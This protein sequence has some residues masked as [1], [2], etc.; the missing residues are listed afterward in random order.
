MRGARLVARPAKRYRTQ[1]SPKRRPVPPET[2]LCLFRPSPR[3]DHSIPP[4]PD[5]SVTDPPSSSS[6][7]P[8]RLPPHLRLIPAVLDHT[9]EPKVRACGQ[10][11][12]APA[13]A[14]QEVWGQAA[15]S[16]RWSAKRSVE[17]ANGC[18][19]QRDRRAV[20]VA[21]MIDGGGRAARGPRA[22]IT[23]RSGR[24]SPG[25]APRA[26]R[27]CA[28]RSRTPPRR[29]RGPRARRQP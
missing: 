14:G 25:G 3:S 6:I 28:R 9:N 5:P 29:V 23:R 12:R 8:H 26:R 18:V 1:L 10:A 17:H 20:I 11:P 19:R 16:Q 4:V 27:I 24:A 22:G 15:R 13:F 21:A 2:P 7:R